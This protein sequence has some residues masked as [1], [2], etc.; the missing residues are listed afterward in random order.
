MFIQDPMSRDLT[1]SLTA[2]GKY[3]MG[4][5]MQAEKEQLVATAFDRLFAAAGVTDLRGRLFFA[6]TLAEPRAAYLNAASQAGAC[7]LVV[8]EELTAGKLA[9]RSGVVNFV[10]NTLDEALR[11]LKNEI[12]KRQPVSVCVVGSVSEIIAEMK[13]RGVRP[14]LAFADVSDV[15]G[16]IIS[17]P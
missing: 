13:V 5:K 6:G 14:D 10:V 17:R 4:E 11:I 12:R 15:G 8:A 9:M 3:S 2:P 1:D 7:S 16:K